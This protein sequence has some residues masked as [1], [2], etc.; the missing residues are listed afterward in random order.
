MCGDCVLVAPVTRPGGIVDV[1]LPRGGDWIDLNDGAPHAGGS[2]LR[3]RVALDALPHF[4]RVGYALPLGR[5]VD[6][7]DAIDTSAPLD[8][9]WLFGAQ[10]V[11]RRGFAQLRST[12]ENGTLD[13]E[14]VG[15][16]RRT[17]G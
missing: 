9:V 10:T 11:E 13:V 8:E 2:L 15:G 7:A 1:Y 3:Q 17:L 14:C 12:S 4:G 5:E 6:R 16:R